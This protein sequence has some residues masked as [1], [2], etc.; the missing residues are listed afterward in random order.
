MC[1]ENLL[2]FTLPISKILQSTDLDISKALNN[3]DNVISVLQ[4]IP[5]NVENEFKIVFNEAYEIADA[6]EITIDI[7]RLTK[8]QTKRCNVP[9]EN[10]E[11]YRRAI[12]IPWLDSFI[13]SISERFL[14]HKGVIKSF[15]CLW[16][17]IF[18]VVEGT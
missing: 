16:L 18:P 4:N 1:V 5:T 10:E 15:K 8:N 2:S 11:Y 17:G 13:N 3:I 7:P 14:K 9:S 12:F 6:L